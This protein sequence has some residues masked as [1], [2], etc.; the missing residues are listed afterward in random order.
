[1]ISQRDAYFNKLFQQAKNDRNIILVSADMGAP[2]LD[3]WRLELPHQYINV[4]IAEANAIGIAVGLARAGKKVFTYAIAPFISLRCYEQI[5]LGPCAHNMPITMIGVGAGFS[6]E[7]SGP[8]HHTLEDFSILATLP[9][10]TV[11]TVTDSVM[12]VGVAKVPQGPTYIR[13]DRAVRE[14]IYNKLT[15]F[16]VG[17]HIVQF[18]PAWRTVVFTQGDLVHSFYGSPCTLIDIHTFPWKLGLGEELKK[19]LPFMYRVQACRII[20]AEENFQS[21]L[22]EQLTKE[23]GFPPMIHLKVDRN[24]GYTYEY[25]GRENIRKQYGLDKENLLSLLVD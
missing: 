1:L 15:F 17:Y 2:A 3:Q 7:D 8:T 4:G 24:L 9:H 12:A 19:L 11:I 23:F 5:K 14:P 21:P 10:M 16:D 18:N 13:L 22:Y 6:Y 20:L 25:G